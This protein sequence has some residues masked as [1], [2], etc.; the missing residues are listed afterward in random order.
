MKFWK[1][2]IALAFAA[3]VFA[4]IAFFGW[5][6]FIQPER[7]EVAAEKAEA[8]APPPTPPPDYSIPVF[9]QTIALKK[10]GKTLETRDALLTFIEQ[11]PESTKLGDAKKIVGDINT[12]L[13]FTSTPGSDK[14]EY[15]VVSGDALVKVASK[16]KSSAELILRSN[17]LSSIDLSI[18]QKLFIPQ[19]D[20]SLVLDRSAKTLSLLNKGKLFKEYPLLALDLPSSAR[21]KEPIVT[22]V[23]DKIALNGPERVAFGSS[24]D[25]IGSERSI[26]L[27]LTNAMIR[28]K[29][30]EPGAEMPSG[31]VVSQEDI[32]EIFP[33]I[34]RGTS[35]TIQ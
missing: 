4:T 8:A 12:S 32:E 25:Y 1:A 5:K 30:E 10:N 19:L 24:R 17:N 3:A 29:S 33:L 35:V 20:I 21:G 23:S 22:K 31:I 14:L 13:V 9:E 6:L 15:T 16:T 18:G 11:Y 26:M 7:L 34:T 27:G 2:L 28:G